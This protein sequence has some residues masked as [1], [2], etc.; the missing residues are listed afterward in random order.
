MSKG[1]LGRRV[2]VV[3][4]IIVRVGS[5]MGTGGSNRGVDVAYGDAQQMSQA[6]VLDT[7]VSGSDG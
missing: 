7:Q 2:E 6:A 4:C 5:M 3:R 1:T